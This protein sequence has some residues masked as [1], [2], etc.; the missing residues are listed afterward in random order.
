MMN[1][2]T[3][4]AGLCGTCDHARR[5]ESARG[6]VFLLCRLSFVDPRFARYPALPVLQCGGFSETLP[7]AS[8]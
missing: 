7:A 4:T 1:D 6:P 5:V 3:E 8:R 2:L